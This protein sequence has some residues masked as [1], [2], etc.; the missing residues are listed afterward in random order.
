[1]DNAK[2]KRDLQYGDP[3]LVENHNG[4]IVAE[5]CVTN[6]LDF[7]EVSSL[8]EYI[9]LTKQFGPFIGIVKNGIDLKTYVTT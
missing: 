7:K 2:N 3:Y 8:T 4:D 1:M 6:Q 9:E 5:R